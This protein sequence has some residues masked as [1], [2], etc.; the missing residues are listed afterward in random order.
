MANTTDIMITSFFDEDAIEFINKNTDLDLK[1]VTEGNRS[2]GPKI[3]SFEAYG[4]C[5]RCIGIKAI[6]NLIAV[7]KDAPFEHPEYAVLLI[8]D[9]DEEFNGLVIRQD[10]LN[11]E[12]K[13]SAI[14]PS[15]FE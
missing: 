5:V 9:D 6:K 10:D 3:L 2:G 11:E 1:Q 12:D 8:D 7:F 14:I 4:T 13:E 15:K